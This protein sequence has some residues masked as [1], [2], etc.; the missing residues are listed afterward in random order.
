MA[1]SQSQKSLVLKARVL[2]SGPERITLDREVCAY[3]VGVIAS[4]LDLLRDFPE[5]D[6]CFPAFFSNQPIESLRTDG[7]DFDTVVDRLFALN[8]DADS[9]FFCLASIHKRRMKFAKI[10]R[11]QRLPRIEEVGPRGL[12]QFGS[13]SPAALTALMVWRKWLYDIDNRAA[14]ETGYLFEPILAHAIGGAP[15]SAR[16]SPVKREDRPEEGRQVDCVFE[17]SAYEFKI[18]VTVAASG[19]G[20]WREELQFPRDCRLSGYTPV[21][22]V[23]DS[24]PS[25]KLSE[26]QEA[27]DANGGES[28]IGEQAW[29]HLEMRAGPTMSRFLR[30]YVRGPINSLL[31]EAPQKLPSLHLSDSDGEIMITIGNERLILGNERSELD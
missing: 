22:I 7:T 19:Q 5:F 3:L 11:T 4:D 1:L 16:Q 8:S 27:F 21:L 25:P 18:R 2:G 14:Q 20:R 31:C 30:N 23:L 24:T 13:L 29:Q 12:L 26:L 17:N 6:G 15:A 28:K 9:Y 10:L